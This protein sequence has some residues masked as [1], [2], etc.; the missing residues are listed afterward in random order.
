MHGFKVRSSAIS[1]LTRIASMVAYLVR[2]GRGDGD[3][4]DAHHRR[5]VRRMMRQ[6]MLLL[7]AAN[8][9]RCFGRSAIAHQP[10]LRAHVHS[11]DQPGDKTSTAS[12]ATGSIR[13]MAPF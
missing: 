11:Y 3:G 13:G 1:D 5:R 8:R 7:V 2:R 6:V 12:T 10:D 4:S 9:P